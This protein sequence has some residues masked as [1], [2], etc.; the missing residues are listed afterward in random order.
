MRSC[1]NQ[2]LIRLFLV[3]TSLRDWYQRATYSVSDFYYYLKDYYYG[4]HDIWLFVSGHSVPI[5]LNNFYNISHVSWIYN[6]HTNTLEKSSTE[7]NRQL[8]KLSWLSAKI[9]VRHD[10]EGEGEGQE[11]EQEQEEYDIDDFLSVFHVKTTIDCAPTLNNI[12]NAWCA[13]KKHWF[14]TNCTVEFY[15]IDDMGQDRILELVE[16]N[17]CLILHRDKVTLA[18]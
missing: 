3:W 4:H 12:F 17:F 8:Y 11:Q 10:G 14:Q 5:S 18:F 13:Y 2:C 9:L 1:K 15:V 6:N 16:H 7:P